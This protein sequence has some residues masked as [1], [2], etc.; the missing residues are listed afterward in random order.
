MPSLTLRP[1]PSSAP[2]VPTEGGAWTEQLQLLLE[3]TGEGIF[4]VDMFGCCNFV[5]GAAAEMLGYATDAV[6][7]A[8]KRA[9][10]PSSARTKSAFSTPA[11][12]TTA[13]GTRCAAR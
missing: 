5:N 2:I 8:A 10:M 6:L 13:Q 4:G 9:A 7:G 3:S 12:V 11:L 1:A